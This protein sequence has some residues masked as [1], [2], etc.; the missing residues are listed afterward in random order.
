MVNVFKYIE[1]NKIEELRDVLRKEI[2]KE[3]SNHPLS[4]PYFEEL[5]ANNK[6]I[7]TLKTNC[8]KFY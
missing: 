2:R 5:N 4:K 8:K 1:K 6:L 7:N 3:M